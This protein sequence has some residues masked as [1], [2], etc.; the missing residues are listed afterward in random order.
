V[1]LK[2]DNIPKLLLSEDGNFIACQI[3]PEHYI[4]KRE[5]LQK[6][7][8]DKSIEETVSNPSGVVDKLFEIEIVQKIYKNFIKPG[9]LTQAALKRKA[10]L[11]Y[12]NKNIYEFF[13]EKVKKFRSL[14]T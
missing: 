4:M 14:K 8:G 9:V 11:I 3:H 7:L 1:I 10:N 2:H 12:T 6:S 5:K 13:F